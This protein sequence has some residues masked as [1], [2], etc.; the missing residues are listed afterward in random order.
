[1]EFKGECTDEVEVNDGIQMNYKCNMENRALLL[2]HVA[3]EVSS[4]GAS[5]PLT[6]MIH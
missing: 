3:L 2:Q 4:S 1:M 6:S 5:F